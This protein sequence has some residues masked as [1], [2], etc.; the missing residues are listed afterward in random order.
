M[1]RLPS[2]AARAAVRTAAAA[3][4]VALA[5]A[6]T[7]AQAYVNDARASVPVPSMLGRGDAGVAVARRETSFFVNPA[8]VA[9]GDGR[10]HVTLAGIGAGL[11]SSAPGVVQRISGEADGGSSCGGLTDTELVAATLQ[12]A[13][14]RGTL[15]LPSFSVRSGNVGVSAGLF[16]T[17]A[18]A[19]AVAQR[20]GARLGVRL[21]ADDIAAATLRARLPRLR[22]D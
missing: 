10:L 3:A 6:P 15:L 4:L 9:A 1:P 12:P 11:T 18:P 2:S 17:P 21:H 22:L 8:H 5:P 7:A 16:H 14:A 20:D 19:R 13:E